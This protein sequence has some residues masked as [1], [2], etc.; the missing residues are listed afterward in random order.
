MR[1]LPES[2]AW[3]SAVPRVLVQFFGHRAHRAVGVEQ[4][5]PLWFSCLTVASGPAVAADERPSK[6][7]RMAD[8]LAAVVASPWVRRWS[9]ARPVQAP[10]WPEPGIRHAS[11]VITL[12]LLA[13]ASTRSNTPLVS[14]VSK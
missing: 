7:R 8:T 1:S 11:A 5:E 14:E 3:Q 9:S 4:I 2:V 12:C 6:T 10:G 13:A